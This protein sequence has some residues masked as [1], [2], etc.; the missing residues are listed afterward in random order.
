VAG[1]SFGAEKD[2]KSEIQG[3]EFKRM[4]VSVLRALAAAVLIGLLVAPITSTPLY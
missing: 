2:L 4:R 1:V 3:L